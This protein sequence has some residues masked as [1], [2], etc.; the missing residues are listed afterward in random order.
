MN[1]EQ[2][3]E[4]CDCPSCTLRAACND[5]LDRGHSIEDIA[6]TMAM[7]LMAMSEGIDSI[8]VIELTEP[9]VAPAPGNGTV[10]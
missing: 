3:D 4:N 7:G 8:S 6:Q 10:H 9:D 5:L 1:H 2:P